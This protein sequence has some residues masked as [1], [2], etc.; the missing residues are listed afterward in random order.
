MTWQERRTVTILSTIL[1]ILCAA[2]LIVLGIRYQEGRDLP[3]GEEPAVPGAVTDPSAF[4]SLFYE[5][6][7]TTLSFSLNEEERW[8]WDADTD[9]PLDTATIT[10]IMELLTSWK[11]QQTI[12]DS[13]T[14]ESCGMG[15]PTATLTAGTAQ[16]GTVTMLLGKATTDGASY[17]MRYNGDESTAYIID[18]ALYQLL[19]VP[20][21]DMCQLPELPQL[22]EDAIQSITIRGAAPAE[23][24]RGVTTVLAAQRADGEDAATT[25]RSGGANVTDDETVRALLL[26]LAA[27]AFEK[28]VDYRPS[29]EAASICGFDAPAAELKVE[30]VTD[31]GVEQTLE[32]TI[33]SPLPDGSGRYTRLGG[34]STI[35]LLPTAALDPL[36][37]VSVNGLEG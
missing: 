7:S 30:F 23:G 35:Y 18:G 37:R 6:G 13:A 1:A 19:C 22:P 21:Y 29:D 33:G 3:D 26:D 12:T 15:T 2:L 20:I 28:C 11:P 27:L 16:G 36:M 34:D 14:L 24:E 10:S 4:N 31:S 17:Y 32:L 5:N 8:V 25:W 9:F